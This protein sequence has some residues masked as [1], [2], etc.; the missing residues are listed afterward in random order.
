MNDLDD[1]FDCGYCDNAFEN[2]V[3]LLAHVESFHG[4]EEKEVSSEEDLAE[5]SNL[6]SAAAESSKDSI[7]DTFE[8]FPC[9]LKFDDED[10]LVEHISEVHDSDQLDNDFRCRICGKQFNSKPRLVIHAQVHDSSI[11]RERPFKCSSCSKG[12]YTS[13]DLW[14]HQRIH[15][16]AKY[17][18]PQCGKQLASTGSLHNHIKSVHRQE[19]E[20]E[21][22]LCDKKFA[23]KQKLTNHIMYA[24]Q[25][26]QK[27]FQCQQCGQGFVHKQSYEAHLRKHNGTVLNCQLCSKPFHDAG[28]LKKHMRWHAKVQESKN[29]A[30]TCSR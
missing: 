24:H 10:T 23:L 17:T 9:Q 27:P 25:N 16:G 8:C 19:K 21:C 11:K 14:S 20:F 13:Q 18:C 2:E 3:T 22:T 5:G 26:G 4:D 7:I 30:E 12:F 6:D 15:L 29:K 28:Y 1:F